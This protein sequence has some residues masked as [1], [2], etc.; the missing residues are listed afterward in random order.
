MGPGLRGRWA[1]ALPGVL[2]AA[3]GG[4]RSLPAACSRGPDAVRYAL[5]SAPGVVRVAGTGLSTCVAR[6]REA[7]EL[8]SVGGSLV[9]AAARLSASARRHPGG[10][11]ELELGYLVGAARRGAGEEGGE[12]S[13]LLRRLEQEG[14]S[15]GGDRAAYWRGVRAGRRSG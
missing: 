6:A 8:Q 15:L 11:A 5:R 9:D 7:G 3:C 14:Q 1:L 12:R 13:E 2:L 4:D 10:A